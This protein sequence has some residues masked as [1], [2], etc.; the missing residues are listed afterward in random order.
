[1]KGKRLTPEKEL[2]RGYERLVGKLGCP[3]A[4]KLRRVIN[5]GLPKKI[6]DPHI[7][8]LE[9][10]ALFRVARQVAIHGE[11][12]AKYAA[13]IYG[14][15]QSEI[16][17]LKNHGKA[18]GTVQ[19]AARSGI[20]RSRT[21]RSGEQVSD[22]KWSPNLRPA[23][24]APAL[25][26]RRR[27][28]EEAEKLCS[29][30]VRR[31]VNLGWNAEKIEQKVLKPLERLLHHYS[32][33]VRGWTIHSI[34]ELESFVRMLKD[35]KIAGDRVRIVV[36]S[37]PRKYVGRQEE[38]FASLRRR[39]LLSDSQITPS[40]PKG[41]PGAREYVDFGVCVVQ[42]LG[43]LERTELERAK[44][45]GHQPASSGIVAASVRVG[46]YYAYIAIKA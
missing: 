22:G 42:V 13:P 8:D 35:C 27:D 11:E 32:L 45:W 16:V 2:L 40:K 10:P 21:I 44:A 15:P 18:L 7:T 39:R 37:V 3:K 25:P 38:W 43:L 36:N 29:L 26:A 19:S 34:K 12:G 24:I 9:L 30:F 17:G 23:D 5:K 14:L 1:M 31:A 6:T 20:R 41:L 33:S 28:R 46:C 4:P